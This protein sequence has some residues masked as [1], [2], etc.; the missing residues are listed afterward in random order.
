MD[1]V[2]VSGR[3]VE[4]HDVRQRL[5]VDAAGRDVGGH[6]HRELALLEAAEGFRPLRLRAVAVD[7]AGV[8]T[9]AHQEVGEAV[10]ARLGAGEDDHAADETA[11]HQFGE[12][13][14]LEVLGHRI[15]GLSDARGGGR[16]TLD[17]D[18][19]RIMQ[20]LA[21]ELRDLR[22]HGGREE[23][24]LALC[25]QIFED[26]ADVGE[27]AHVEH[28]VGFVQHED[29]E[30]PE[31]RIRAIHV[32]E[33]AAGG[34]HDDVGAA[35]KRV[36][37][38]AHADASVDGGG[39]D[40]GVHPESV[41]VLVDLR[42]EFSRGGEDQRTGEA[43]RL[44]AEAMN[45]GEAERGALAAAGHGA[46]EQVAP[47]DTGRKGLLLNGSRV[48]ETELLDAAQKFGRE[49]VFGKRHG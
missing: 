10:R 20:H 4:V 39:G 35:A 32:V 27:E 12:K 14:R 41:Q 36:L 43:L 11:I 21:R 47:L 38:G 25:G 22:R 44:A 3:D 34:G 40:R 37:L 46:G 19:E 17:A 31:V 15:R 30:V 24:G 18:G 16:L 33:E 9:H 2:L 23:E 42:R 13:N 7:A 28:P 26:A 29:L 8:H 49:A 1:V 45:D 6:E 48:L 5:D